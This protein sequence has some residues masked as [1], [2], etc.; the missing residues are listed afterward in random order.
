[1]L[2]ETTKVRFLKTRTV[3]AADGETGE[4]FQEGETYDLPLASAVR[5]IRRGVA[6]AVKESDRRRVAETLVAGIAGAVETAALSPAETT[7]G[8]ATKA[9]PRRRA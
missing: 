9:T 7:A 3:Q 4:T 6:A 5:W 8:V 2:E 1:M